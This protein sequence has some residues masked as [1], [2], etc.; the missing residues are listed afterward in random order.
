MLINGKSMRTIE[1]LDNFCLSIIDQTLLPHRLKYR[2]LNNLEDVFNAISKMWV[3][4]APLIGVTAAYGMSLA[5]KEDASDKNINIAEKKLLEARPTAVDLK[6]AISKVK[7][8]IFSFKPRER[9]EVAWIT[10]GELAEDS[11]KQCSKIG[12]FGK[13]LI[14]KNSPNNKSFNNLTHCN[15]GWLACVDWGT[16]L[17][18][19]YKLFN[20]GI[21]VHVWVDETRPRSQGAL[22]T[23]WELMQ[24]GV[25]NTLI[26]DNVG[27]HLMQSGKVDMCIVGSDR[28]ASNGDVCNKIGTYLKALAAYDNGLPFYVGL[29]S[30]TIDWTVRDGIRDIPIEERDQSEVTVLSGRAKDGKIASVKLTPEG[31]DAANYAF[32]VTPRRLVTGLITERGVCDASEDGLRALFP[33]KD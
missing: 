1:V 23:T 11:I 4:G 10:S 19:I 26:V 7:E 6:W 9:F 14:L 25:P 31:S 27:G 13:E 22:L 28:T 15:A 17:S 18:P 24:H 2:K 33:E 5:I 32:D 16:A 3:R 30:P 20:E 12:D 21:D 8:K 29:P